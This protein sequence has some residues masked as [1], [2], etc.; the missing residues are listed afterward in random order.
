MSNFKISYGGSANLLVPNDI[1]KDLF[2]L[3]EQN[4]ENMYWFGFLY[5]ENGIFSRI[6]VDIENDYSFQLIKG[7]N[8]HV[9][10]K[11]KTEFLKKLLKTILNTGINMKILLITPNEAFLYYIND[12][13]VSKI[14]NNID[15]LLEDSKLDREEMINKK[16][17]S[18]FNDK[19][20]VIK[21]FNKDD[22]LKFDK[23]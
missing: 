1:K 10:K 13:E 17:E 3:T 8:F 4:I 23:I 11:F 12:D 20:F 7:I 16:F 9:D 15:R 21:K 19:I 5:F 2:D 14:N 18:I 6:I 22:E